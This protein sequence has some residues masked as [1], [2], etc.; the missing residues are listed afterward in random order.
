MA[1]F[2]A[3]AAGAIAVPLNPGFKPSEL[4]YLLGDARAGL[5][6]VEPDGQALVAGIDPDADLLAVDTGRPYQ[7][8]DVVRSTRETPPAVI[9]GPDDPALIIY[10]SGTTGDPKGAVLT[11]GNLIHDARHIIDIWR[12]TDD[13][14]LCHALP[15]FHVHGLCFALHTALLSGA[16]VRML[17]RFE[18]GTVLG[19]LSRDTGHAPCT[20]FMAVPAMYTRIMD[21]LGRRRPQFGHLRL[22]AS[23]SAPLPVRE[24]ARITEIF[25]RE[26]VEREGMSET[27]MNFSNPLNGRRVPG[28][29]GLPLPGVEVRIVDPE[30]L[31]DVAP[32][33]V[34][35]LWLKSGA[36]TPGY[37]RKPAESAEAFRDG[38]FRTGDLGR[39]DDAGYRLPDRPHQTHHHL[40]RRKCFGQGGGD[41]HQPDRRGHRIGGGGQGR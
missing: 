6:L 5:V 27:G 19:E 13:D 8:M 34:G 28:S 16:A 21:D 37:W 12:I 23:G 18:P 24:F 33:A 20:L 9:V 17:D 31:V 7:D 15:L 32:G 1:H 29:I 22:L 36:V 26:P 38:W 35:E 4:A 30:T 40:R 3:Q 25:G 14:V 2:A 39:E 11:H 10:T 41:G